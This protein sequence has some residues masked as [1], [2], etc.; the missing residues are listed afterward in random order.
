MTSAVGMIEV[1]GVAGIIAAAD[2][3]LKAAEIELLGWE[4]IG[5]FTTLFFQ[6]QLG[7]VSAA[8]KSGERAALDLASTAHRRLAGPRISR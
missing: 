4:S 7:A 8:L 5:G 1:E 2:A 3:A 6:G